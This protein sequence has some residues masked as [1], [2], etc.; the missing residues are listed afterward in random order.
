MAP[1]SSGQG[2]K[3]EKKG[4]PGGKRHRLTAGEVRT[5]DQES[6]KP[7]RGPPPRRRVLSKGEVLGE[8]FMSLNA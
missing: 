2:W 6:R 1:P 4:G 5:T 7:M 8:A 3:A